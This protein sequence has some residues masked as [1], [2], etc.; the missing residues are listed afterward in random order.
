LCIYYFW[1]ATPFD[2]IKQKYALRYNA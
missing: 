2:W 1:W